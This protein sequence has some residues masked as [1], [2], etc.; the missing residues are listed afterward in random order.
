MT[1]IITYGAYVENDDSE[2][3]ISLYLKIYKNLNYIR[4]FIICNHII[5]LPEYK[6]T[7]II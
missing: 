1:I 3:I 4:K 2:N 6:V 5:L 7:Y